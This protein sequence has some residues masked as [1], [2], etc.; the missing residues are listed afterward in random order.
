[1]DE[2]S[3][4]R[5][6]VYL[7]SQPGIPVRGAYTRTTE[8]EYASMVQLLMNMRDLVFLRLETE[9]KHVIFVH[10]Q[11]ISYVELERRIDE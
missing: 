5:Y 10:P 7:R 6:A 2:I 11:D 3:Y 9:D 1:M 4:W 8:D